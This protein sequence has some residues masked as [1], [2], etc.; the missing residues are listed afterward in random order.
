V[1]IW[2]EPALNLVLMGGY[3]GLMSL[4]WLGLWWG[5]PR[6]AARWRLDRP[7]A[8]PAAP[9]TALPRVSVCVPARDEALNIGDCV[10][11]A[12]ASR[13]AELELVV[14]DD[15][16]TDGT[17][18]AALAAA[19]GDPRLR[20]V[21]GTERPAGWAGKAWACARAA[22]EAQGEWLLFID[23][24]VRVDPDA[25]P[26]LVQQAERD[27]LDLLSVFGRWRLD[28]FWER[29]LI[30]TVGWF[31]RGA[32][33]LDRVNAP[34][35]PAAFANGQMILVRRAAYEAV[36]G[37]GAIRA[38]ILDDVRIAELMKRRGRRAGMRAAPWAFEVRLY[39]NLAEIVNGYTKNLYEGM[40]RRAA[41]GV[42]AVLFVMV[43]T[44][45]PYVLAVGGAAARLGAGWGAPAWGWI[46]W[47]ALICAVQ[48]A[49][50]ARIERFDGRSPHIAWVH[51][52]A[53]ILLVWILLRSVF[54]VRVQWKG[55]EF[56]DG[57]AS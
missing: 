34:Q 42:G 24:D 18:A 41:I 47:A 57:K 40:G 29:A 48:V 52:V 44:L 25:I 11:S 23:A 30:P 45:F 13:W 49:F 5:V 16:S 10:R 56:V 38:E 46:L 27:G 2:G 53:N 19:A 55:R 6:W 33:D 21:Q 4:M 31:I 35:E 3:L 17:G 9:T 26:A 8:A 54:G 22:G 12:L 7:A 37:H 1:I 20:L 36:G 15:R 32:V 28:S 51:P 14:V 43:G 39:R 50:R